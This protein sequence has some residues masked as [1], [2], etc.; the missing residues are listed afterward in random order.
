M[1]YQK[2][3]ECLTFEVVKKKNEIDNFSLL[4]CGVDLL[5]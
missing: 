2:E 5:W 3:I 1:K 4:S